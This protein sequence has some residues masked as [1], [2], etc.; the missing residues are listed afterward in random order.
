MNELLQPMERYRELVDD[1]SAFIDSLQRPLP[2]CLWTNTLRC[3][4]AYLRKILE[5]EHLEPE[6]LPW[7]PDAFRIQP[8]DRLGTRWWYMAG[9]CHSQEEV[10]L[11]PVE[12]LDCRP[13]QRVLDLC[14]AP[15]GKTARIALA[16]QN[17]GTI[18]ANDPQPGRMNMLR[19]NLKRLGILNVTTVLRDAGSFPRRAGGFDRILVDAPCSCE[20]TFRKHPGTVTG[21]ARRPVRQ[22]EAFLATAARLCRPGGRIVYSTCTFA[23]EENEAVVHAVLQR[24]E[25]KDLRVVRPELPDF[26]F[27][28]GVTGW[29]GVQFHPSLADT[30]RVW[31]HHNDSGGFF[32]AVLEKDPG[33]R[34]V[35]EIPPALTATESPEVDD[36]IF[37]R[38]GIPAGS[39]SGYIFHQRT[40]KGLYLVSDGHTPPL[41]PPPYASGLVFMRTMRPNKPSTPAALILGN[42][43][44]R[45]VVE[46]REEE[47]SLFHAREMFPVE[48][49]RLRNADP[50]GTVIVRYQGIP[51]GTAFYPRSGGRLRSL[52]PKG[53]AVGSV[54]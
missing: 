16:L 14:A 53:W 40:S 18:V 20:G 54:D 38:F 9:L 3:E 34:E 48:E 11:L 19:S 52:F 29:E 10:S 33:A 24:S 21:E 44:T 32:V 27:S 1:W 45:N 6:P 41:D 15:G 25:G 36:A 8:C 43:A 47:I 50:D 35:C 39:I 17:R 46:L 37:A 4:S 5:N 42:L 22:Q 49:E 26:R 30:F 23:P 2:T 13:G 31:P 7:N 12:L 51:L 28:A